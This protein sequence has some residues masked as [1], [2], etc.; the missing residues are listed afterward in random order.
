MTRFAPTLANEYAYATEVN[1]ATLESLLLKKSSA[2]CDI[3]RQ[4]D[5]CRRMLGVCDAFKAQ[6]EWS[7]SQWRRDY[8][9]VEE[10]IKKGD[11]GSSLDAWMA[12]HKP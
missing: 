6:I 5:I 11:L 3:R 1:L 2:K 10:L 12:E 7:T 9:R 8:G 4:R